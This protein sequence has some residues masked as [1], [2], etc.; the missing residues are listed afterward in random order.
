MK[1]IT[2]ISL[3]SFILISSNLFA[4]NDDNTKTVPFQITLVTPIGMNGTHAG[5][6]VNKVSINIL[7]GYAAGLKGAEFG[8]LANVNRNF[9]NGAQFAGLANYTGGPANGAQ[10]AGITN[11]NTGNTE[12][13]QFSGIANVN[14]GSTRGFQAAGIA[15]Y[16]MGFSKV[17]QA[18]GI[19]NFANQVKGAQMA[20]IGNFA[21]GDVNGAQIAGIANFA[22]GDVDGAQIAGIGNFSHS[23]NG[24]QIAGIANIT[25]YADGAQIAG[26]LNVTRNI[27]GTQIGFINIADTIKRGIPIGFLSIV[28]DGYREFEVGFS[29]GLNTYASFKIGVSQFYNIFSIGTQFIS[30]HFRWGVGY[31]IG[32]HL[33]N[34]ENFKINLEAMSYQINEGSTWTDAY[35]GLQQLKL[36]FAGGI[37][38]HVLLFAGPTF[39]LMVS[40]YTQINGERGSNFPP[41]YITNNMSGDTNLKFWIG[42]SAGIRIR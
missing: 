1:T 29:E 28:R 41:Y 18:A 23:T 11:V 30:D 32:T 36:T 31:G 39:N 9:M 33:A 34:K 24:V 6:T 16:T 27:S 22:S 26:I 17:V 38:P 5:N 42:F 10:F 8:G 2:F 4:Q 15:N 19:G 37:N 7:A 21:A 3:F 20:G 13:A 40:D 14:I 35:N 25:E 12:L